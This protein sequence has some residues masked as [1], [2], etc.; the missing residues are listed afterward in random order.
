MSETQTEL[1]QTLNQ[2]VN[3]VISRILNNGK[4]DIKR[5]ILDKYKNELA[6]KRVIIRVE[7]VPD[8]NT[9]ATNTTS[10]CNC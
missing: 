9:P 7:I 3:K 4:D 6:G 8:T 1:E 2:E 10:S 5:D